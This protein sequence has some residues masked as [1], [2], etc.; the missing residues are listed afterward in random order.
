MLHVLTMQLLTSINIQKVQEVEMRFTDRK[1]RGDDPQTVDA[2]VI[3]GG[4]TF[5]E[6]KEALQRNNLGVDVN[7][8]TKYWVVGAHDVILMTLDEIKDARFIPLL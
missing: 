5:A 7:G 8:I 3:E 4:E 1:P 6:V 2:L